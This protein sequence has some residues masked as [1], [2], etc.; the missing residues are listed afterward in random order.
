MTKKLLTICILAGCISAQDERLRLK[1]ADVLENRTIN[2]E[3]VQFLTGNV[4]FQKKDM[5]LFCDRARYRQKKGLGMLVGSVRVTR[6]D[7]T[8]TCDSLHINSPDDILTG[9]GRAHAWTDAYDLTSDTLLYFSESDSGSAMGDVTLIQEGQTITA[10]KI[11]YVESRSSEGVSYSAH[12]NVVIQDSLRTA[13]AGLRTTIR[14]R[15]KRF[16]RLNRRLFKK[17]KPFPGRKFLCII[18][19]VSLN[20]FLFQSRRMLFTKRTAT[21]RFPKNRK[22]PFLLRESLRSIPMI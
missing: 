15:K 9:Y 14:M 19:K 11:A 21:V 12:Q 8:L 17:G 18:K 2:G 5:T 6:D 13:T 22:I 10:E 1:R 20:L 7:Q 16:L 4:V 3:A